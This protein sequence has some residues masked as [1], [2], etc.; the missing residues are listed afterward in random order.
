MKRIIQS[1]FRQ[2]VTPAIGLAV[3][4]ALLCVALQAAGQA[5]VLR[6][7]RQ[8][9]E[10]GQVWLLLTGNFVHLGVSHLVM[11][12]A[13]LALIVALVWQRFSWIE[14]LLITLISSLVVGMGLYFLNADLFWYVG[15]SG[16]LHGLIIA[17]CLA[18][19]RYFPKSA[20]LLLV[21]V[22][23]K[24]AW[25]QMAGALPGSESVAG[26]NVIVD[27]HLYGAVGGALAGSVLLGL[28]RIRS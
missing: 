10:A 22:I 5:D 6:F 12:M 2:L 18:D 9:I 19:L 8:A 28:R 7:D 26:G 24:L 15:F 1:I 27:A 20:G 4:I 13:G 17:G 23:G 14:W 16:T 11:N 25:E 3:A 21:L